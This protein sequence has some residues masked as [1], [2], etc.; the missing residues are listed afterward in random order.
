MHPKVAQAI[1]RHSQISMTMD[2]YA[3]VVGDSERE[4]VAMLAELLE[5]PLTG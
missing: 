2:V 3:H 5:D 1:L 4:A